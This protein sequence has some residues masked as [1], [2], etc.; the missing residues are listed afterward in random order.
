MTNQQI[1]FTVIIP[2]RSRP[3]T[4]KWALKSCVEQQYEN[5]E[6]IVCD[7]HSQDSTIDIVN[8]Y[9][10]NRIKYVNPGRRLSMSDNWEFALQQAT[11]DYINYIG[12]DDAM[13]PRAFVNAIISK[14]KCNALSWVKDDFVY[15]WP[16]TEHP[17]FLSIS[18]WGDREIKEVKSRELLI[19]IQSLKASYSLLPMIYSGTIKKSLI[20]KITSY[21]G[22]FF[23]AASP[24]VDSGVAVTC[25]SDFF[26]R[27]GMPYSMTGCSKHSIGA[28]N[29]S[30]QPINSQPSIEFYQENSHMPHH[31]L[32]V[33]PVNIH[34][35]VADSILIARDTIPN[36]D[37]LKIDFD[38]LMNRIA[39]D[40]I[41]L[42]PEKHTTYIA[43]VRKIGQL[44]GL[45][46]QA[47]KLISK[48]PNQPQ[49]QKKNNLLKRANNIGTVAYFNCNDFGINNVYDASILTDHVLSM[50]NSGCFSL[51]YKINKFITS[52]TAS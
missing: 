48:L 51:K 4:L 50:K 40:A 39:K 22:R 21:R 1:K 47:E 13:M 52:I 34:M 17:N 36:T 16:H 11:G 32:G 38:N 10:D 46:N 24:D 49:I 2:T 29:L 42:S 19:N 15:F 45:E 8:S 5:L 43:A 25:A 12:D 9:K 33:D 31:Q 41:N 37:Y 3:D 30:N 28:S 26:F 35:C 18:L 27:S 20:D 14:L 23:S 44:N 6:I 7:N